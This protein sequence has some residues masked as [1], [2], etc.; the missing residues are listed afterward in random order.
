MKCT[1]CGE[2]ISHPKNHTCP[3]AHLKTVE[4]EITLTVLD[5][6]ETRKDIEAEI[7]VFCAKL[8]ELSGVKHIYVPIQA[9]TVDQ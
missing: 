1:A 6:E 4:I 8:E 2:T 5:E 7:N 3:K 9:R